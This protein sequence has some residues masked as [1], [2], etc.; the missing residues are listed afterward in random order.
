[1]S[2]LK[3]LWRTCIKLYTHIDNNNSLNLI[4]S[5][6]IITAHHYFSSKF[7]PFQS[8]FRVKSFLRYLV[9]DIICRCYILWVLT[10]WNMFSFCHHSLNDKFIYWARRIFYIF[11]HIRVFVLFPFEKALLHLW[12]LTFRL[13][14]TFFA[15]H[16]VQIYS[17]DSSLF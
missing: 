16:P 15:N 3:I 1:M 5:S 8:M 13:K 14:V 10:C 9:H 7:L 12:S 17:L 6:N 2:S 4:L 11:F